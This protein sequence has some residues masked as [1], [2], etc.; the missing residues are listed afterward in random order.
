MPPPSA[1]S[2]PGNVPRAG[3]EEDQDAA[4]AAAEG[5]EIMEEADEQEE[6]YG[7]SS[8]PI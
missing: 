4:L 8:F 6:G 7:A 3:L 1:Q 2:L 5:D